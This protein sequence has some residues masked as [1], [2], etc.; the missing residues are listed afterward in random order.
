M[1]APYDNLIGFFDRRFD[2]TSRPG[3]DACVLGNLKDYQTYS[4]LHG[5][6][7]YMYQACV[8]V[9][10]M[11]MCW[12]PYLGKD[13]DA[14]SFVWTDILN[15]LAS[16]EVQ[17]G[18]VFS[19]FADSA[20]PRSRYCQAILKSPPG[21]QLSQMERRFNALMARFRIVIEN[22]FAEISTYWNTLQHSTNKKMGRQD[23]GRMF[24]CC[25]WLHNVHSIFAGNQTSAY[26]GQDL[27]SR[28]SLEEYLSIAHEYNPH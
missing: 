13:H 12:G 24:P 21:G 26:F 9:N 28:I 19:V 7:G 5:A 20:Y 14:K 25:V 22:L 16:I 11:S 6:H 2:Q 8:L 4:F 23:I 10:G 27:I 3:G 1:G 15:D 17:I 18:R